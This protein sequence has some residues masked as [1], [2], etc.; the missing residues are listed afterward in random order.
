MA[1]SRHLLRTSYHLYHSAFNNNDG[2]LRQSGAT[3]RRTHQEFSGHAAET[4]GRHTRN[5]TVVFPL[6]LLQRFPVLKYSTAARSSKELDSKIKNPKSVCLDV[7]LPLAHRQSPGT[8]DSL[9]TQ[10]RAGRRPGDSSTKCW[11]SKTHYDM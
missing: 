3:G 2:N 9:R 1:K 11:S 7:T 6:C 4:S 10:P 5:S 8:E